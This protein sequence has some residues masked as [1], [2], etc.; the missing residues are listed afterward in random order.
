MRAQFLWQI[1]HTFDS[2]LANKKWDGIIVC[3]VPIREGEGGEIRNVGWRS[4]T[5]IIAHVPI[6]CS[7]SNGIPD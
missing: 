6:D 2:V 4:G 3:A 1:L 5:S 7:I